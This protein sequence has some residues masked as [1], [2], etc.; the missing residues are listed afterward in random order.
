[1]TPALTP[2]VPA[3]PV[4]APVPMIPAP[5]VP[6]PVPPV[7]DPAPAAAAPRPPVPV[8][9]FTLCEI[10]IVTSRL[11]LFPLSPVHVSLRSS[12]FPQS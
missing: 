11:L 5:P 7:P 10:P 4:P 3:L 9:S 12:T 6:N 8:P 1:M 2:D